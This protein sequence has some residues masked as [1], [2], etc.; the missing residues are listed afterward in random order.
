MKTIAITLIHNK[1]DNEQQ[2]IDLLDIIEPVYETVSAPIE[3]DSDVFEDVTRFLYYKFK[4]DSNSTPIRVLQFV[5]YG[6]EKP[7]NIYDIES[8]NIIFSNDV[9]D[10]DTHWYNVALRRAQ[11]YGCDKVIYVDNVADIDPSTILSEKSEIAKLNETIVTDTKASQISLTADL[12][13]VTD[14]AVADRIG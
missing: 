9:P 4:D 11:Q 13:Q 1:E 14:S 3:P 10:K 8:H 7:K 12:K 2:I 5:P 6:F